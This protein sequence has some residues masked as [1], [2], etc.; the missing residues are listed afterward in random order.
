MKTKSKVRKHRD[1]RVVQFSIRNIRPRR[2]G[3]I[4]GVA[5]VVI[6]SFKSKKAKKTLPRFIRCRGK[7]VANG[8]RKVGR[9]KGTKKTKKTKKTTKK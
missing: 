3:S 5:D 8:S 2:D 9:P 6:V 7:V 4:V 1:Y